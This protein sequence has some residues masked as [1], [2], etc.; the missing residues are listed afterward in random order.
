V[1]NVWVVGT[2][3]L[4]W[5]FLWRMGL[6]GP[7][8]GA[9][10]G[11]AYDILV[12]IAWTAIAT[13]TYE[14]IEPEVANT[15][16]AI[17]LGSFYGML[18]GVILSVLVS[19]F[20]G[21]LG[22]LLLGILTRVFYYPASGNPR[23]YYLMM[24]LAC[25]VASLLILYVAGSLVFDVVDDLSAFFTNLQDLTLDS[26]VAPVVFVNLPALIATSAMGLTGTLVSAW[27]MSIAGARVDA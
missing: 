2:V 12:P 20:L 15:L 23:R 24:G 5:F 18:A 21:G 25:A 14:G 22:G 8:L 6:L 11:G 7:D 1:N 13:F 10:L 16:G 9:V 17:A 3:K 4:L 26:A 27:Y 19:F